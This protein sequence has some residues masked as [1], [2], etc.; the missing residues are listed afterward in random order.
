MQDGSRTDRLTIAAA[1]RLAQICLDD[2]A[3]LH[4]SRW[5][6]ATY[7]A[8]QALE[9]LIRAVATSEGVHIPRS[10]AHQLD[11][12]VR[13]LP[14]SNPEKPFLATLCWLE[15]Y[16]TT[17]DTCNRRA[18]SRRRPIRT[19]SARPSALSPAL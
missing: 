4:E 10:D 7:L 15:A 19:G 6:N 11:K 3:L 16:A 12:I 2:A 18:A 1:L 17:F 13:L 9:Q 14:D 5:R 8:E